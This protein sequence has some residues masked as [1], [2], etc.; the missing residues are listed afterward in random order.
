MF[1]R[2]RDP[3]GTKHLPAAHAP[4]EMK[5]TSRFE[6][7]VPTPSYPYAIQSNSPASPESAG[8]GY[9]QPEEVGLYDVSELLSR[10]SS[11]SSPL[12]ASRRDEIRKNKLWLDKDGEGSFSEPSKVPMKML[13]CEISKSGEGGACSRCF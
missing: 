13:S 7:R 9:V 3:S 11:S 5:S 12:T 6:V 2:F 4:V 10:L 8:R 1:L